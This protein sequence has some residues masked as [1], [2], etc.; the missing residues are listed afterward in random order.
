ME[1]NCTSKEDTGITFRFSHENLHIRVENNFDQP[2][3]NAVIDLLR[4]NH[5]KCKR[6]F[7][8]VRRVI[9]THSLAVDALKSLLQH[10]GP[11]PEQVHFKGKTGF[12]MAVSGNRVLLLPEKPP[13]DASAHEPHE[14]H[15]CRGNC[16]QCRCGRH[17][18]AH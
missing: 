11:C 9:Q 18:H 7:I 10:N 6:I 16:A 15:V 5:K 2:Q 1:Q 12:G 3:A 4:C 17:K 8:D 14:K 13:R